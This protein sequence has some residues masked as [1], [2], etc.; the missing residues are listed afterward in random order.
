K[1]DFGNTLINTL[2]FAKLS[3]TWQYFFQQHIAWDI[4]KLNSFLTTGYILL[5]MGGGILL[6]TKKDIG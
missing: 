4:V 1:I 6:F 3:D 2:F 5:F